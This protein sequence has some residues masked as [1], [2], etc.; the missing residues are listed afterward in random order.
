MSRMSV[1]IFYSD[2][3]DLEE[4]IV[5]FLYQ[6]PNINIKQIGQSQSVP[7]TQPS[8]KVLASRITISIFYTIT[9]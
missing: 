7:A 3:G 8:D 4:Q 5:K 1:K 6:N 9:T 2:N